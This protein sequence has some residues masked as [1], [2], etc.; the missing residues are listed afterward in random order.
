[1]AAGPDE[2]RRPGGGNRLL[3]HLVHPLV[4]Q[5]VDDGVELGAQ[6]GLGEDDLAEPFPVQ[7]A[8][9]L[10][11]L[12]AE[13]G[14]DLPESRGAGLDDLPRGHVR[15][16]DRGAA[17][18]EPPRHLALPGTDPPGK[19]DPKHAIQ[20]LRQKASGRSSRRELRPLIVLGDWRLSPG[21]ALVAGQLVAQRREGLI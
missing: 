17:I 20:L 13:H 21:S 9:R 10:E 14:G 11:H 5:R 3:L 1:M 16:H 7:V 15:V 19:P 8:V 4:D 12:R 18:G 2:A 6:V